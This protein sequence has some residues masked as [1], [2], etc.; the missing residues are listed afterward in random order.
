MKRFIK[1]NTDL[2]YA[3]TRA[4]LL[5][6]ARGSS[7]YHQCARTEKSLVAGLPSTLSGIMVHSQVLRVL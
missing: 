4:L 6:T 1:V 2:K 3:N 7:Y 5:K